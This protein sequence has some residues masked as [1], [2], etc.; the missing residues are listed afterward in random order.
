MDRF[1]NHNHKKKRFNY[2]EKN[3]INDNCS[4]DSNNEHINCPPSITS[5]ASDNN[6]QTVSNKTKDVNT[7]DTTS[8][9]EK[10]DKYVSLQE[11][12]TYA[13]SEQAYTQ[14]NSKDID[15][16]KN[17]IS[18]TNDLLAKVNTESNI[19]NNKI[20][21]SK[22]EKTVDILISQEQDGINNGHVTIQ[23]YKA[24]K[25]HAGVTKISVRW[26]YARVWVSKS[27][28]RD[29]GTLTFGLAGVFV[30]N[31]ALAA[32]CVI[33][34]FASSKAP[35]GIRFDYNYFQAAAHHGLGVSNV[36]WQ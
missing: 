31:R 1:K 26:N 23:T 25:H 5:F 9:F 15:L 10:A 2:E 16:I 24:S 19:K 36:H 4:R 18:K 3:H 8:L 14:F 6:L 29:G 21:V 12:G 33:L 28:L 7:T 32:A 35:A 11:N 27:A 30:P 17:Q 20:S 13:L 34:G 22:N